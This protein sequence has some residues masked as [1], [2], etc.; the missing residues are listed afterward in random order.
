MVGFNGKHGCSLHILVWI[1]FPWHGF[2]FSPMMQIN[3]L[4]CVPVPQAKEQVDHY[5][6][7]LQYEFKEVGPASASSLCKI[8]FPTGPLVL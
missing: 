1:G 5:Y 7:S 3:C 2:A 8:L 4:V 6:K